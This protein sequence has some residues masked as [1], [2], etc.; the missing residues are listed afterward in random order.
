MVKNNVEEKT[1]EARRETIIKEIDGL[2][3]TVYTSAF[4]M[5]TIIVIVQLML[6]FK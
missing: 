5:T 4:A 3:R 1:C 6:T 2:K